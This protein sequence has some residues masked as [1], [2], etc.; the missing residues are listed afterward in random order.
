MAVFRFRLEKLLEL[1]R[2]HELDEATRLASARNAA[3][4]AER[5]RA[6][7][8]AVHAAGVVRLA[9]AHGVGGT[10]GQLQN[11]NHILSLMGEQVREA[12][13]ACEAANE[14]V[15]QQVEDLAAAVRDRQLL[16]DLRQRKL[17]Q[18]QAGQTAA[19]R[20]L[21]DEIALGRFVRGAADGATGAEATA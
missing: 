6:A 11:L 16:S 10:A 1:R 4:E 7:L 19:D 3:D 14:Q 2:N 13:A 8:E 15:A 9:E 17:L 18:W 21:M 20:K 5:L 12:D